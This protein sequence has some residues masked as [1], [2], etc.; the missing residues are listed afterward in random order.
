MVKIATRYRMPIVTYGCVV[1]IYLV[2]FHINELVSGGTS[3]EGQFRGVRNLF[4]F[5]QTDTDLS[6]SMTQKPLVSLVVFV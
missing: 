2:S 3:L 6:R 5:S 4:I 1:R